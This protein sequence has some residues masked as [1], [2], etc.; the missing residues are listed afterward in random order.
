MACE[1]I[2]KA[3]CVGMLPIVAACALAPL[4][5][6]DFFFTFLSGGFSPG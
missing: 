3:S 1:C 6:G 2:V 4:K 5:R